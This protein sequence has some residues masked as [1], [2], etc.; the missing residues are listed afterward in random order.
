VTT[1]GVNVA[2][3]FD[4][5][6][7]IGEAARQVA[8][9]LE[10]GG[11]FVARVGL[12]HASSPRSGAGVGGDAPYPC[13]LVCTTPEGMPAARDEL[14]PRAFE[15]RRAIGLL[16]WELE[17]L[18]ARWL[19]SFD[20]LDEVWAG[21]RFVADGLGAVAP[22]PVVRVP[23]P[24]A[25]PPVVTMSRG[26]LGLPGGFLFG[27]VFDPAS[28]FARKNPLGLV[29]AFARAFPSPE[30]DEQLVIKTL[31]G[32]RDREAQATL[33]RAAAAHPRVHV[34]DRLLPV[35]QKNA[36]I[37]SLDCYV[38]L[39]RSEGFGLT[40]AEAMLLDVPVVA[41][42]HGG[43]RDFVTSFNAWLVDWAAEAI[44]PGHNPYPPSGVWAAPDVEHAAATLRAVRD[45]P[46]EAR[47]RAQRAYTEVARDHAPA[48]AGRA[49]VARLGRL[50]GLPVGASGAVEA[51]DLSDLRRRVEGGS[52]TLGSALGARAAAR[53]A[54]LRVLR[55]Y[56]VHQRLVHEEL[57]RLL[58]TLDERVHGLAAGQAALAAEVRSLDEENG[59]AVPPSPP[60]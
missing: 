16:W 59:R 46:D 23:L 30:G 50:A 21:S 48:A 41:T 45:A 28:G 10:E 37:A 27:F 55:P 54:L 17:G 56:S 19:R 7:G 6:L 24:V 8:A 43:S 5:T 51:L 3:Y 53:R 31:A 29:E 33:A 4:A 22:V 11:A 40:I 26:N 15:G 32:A 2:G 20:G 58:R 52:A 60:E 34:L 35:E 39:H 25:R 42:D 1:V 14:G 18:P 49:M 44:G 47:R 13:T 12:T 9:A 38:S 57:L 36:L